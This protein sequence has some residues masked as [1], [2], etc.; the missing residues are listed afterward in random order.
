MQRIRFKI[1]AE[2]IETKDEYLTL[3]NMGINLFQGFM[4]AHPSFESL[5][6]LNN[7]V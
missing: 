6:V 4:F 7:Y 5:S 2:R 1:I 3:T